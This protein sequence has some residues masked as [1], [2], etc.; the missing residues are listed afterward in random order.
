MAIKTCFIAIHRP[1]CRTYTKSTALQPQKT[2]TTAMLATNRRFLSN[3]QR[4]RIAQSV[5]PGSV[6]PVLFGA[7]KFRFALTATTKKKVRKNYETI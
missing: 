3:H 6:I 5:V 4:A 1:T 7:M 2:A